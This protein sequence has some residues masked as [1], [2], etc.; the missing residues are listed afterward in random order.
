[1]TSS[2]STK[3]LQNEILDLQM[4]L[5]SQIEKRVKAEKAERDSYVKLRKTESSYRK[6]IK[7]LEKLRE[8]TSASS[9]TANGPQATQK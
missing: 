6:A 5:D 1:M 9:N 4:K 3:D 2:K 8:S 7:E